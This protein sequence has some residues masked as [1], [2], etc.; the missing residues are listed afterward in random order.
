MGLLD[1]LLRRGRR[2]Q[3]PD[4]DAKAALEAANE[5]AVKSGRQ[6]TTWQQLDRWNQASF[7]AIAAAL[8]VRFARERARVR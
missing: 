6:P 1:R 5:I 7:R 2:D 3:D 8:R 4:G